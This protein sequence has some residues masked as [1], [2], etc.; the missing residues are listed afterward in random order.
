MTSHPLPEPVDVARTRRAELLAALTA[1]ERALAA[2]ARDPTWAARVQAR[3][4]RLANSFGDHVA[5]TE[6]P[7]G[8][9]G[10]ILRTAPRLNFAVDRLA[11]EHDDIRTSITA[12]AKLVDDLSGPD[13]D[14]IERIRDEGTNLLARLG[15]HRQRGA[16]LVFEA[17]AQDIGGCD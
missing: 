9:Y 3:T 10:D 7:D 14:A 11:S 12:L 8:M 5:A 17:Y 1:L 2:P 4:D 6:G 16:D 13:T 15:R